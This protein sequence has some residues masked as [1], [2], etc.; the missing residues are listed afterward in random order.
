MLAL[1]T[2]LV[3]LAL[4]VVSSPALAANDWW[5]GESVGAVW[6]LEEG[7]ETRLASAGTVFPNAATLA[8][9]PTGRALLVHESESVFVGPSTVIAL[10]Q[11]GGRTRVIQIAGVA[12]FEVERR[13]VQHFTVETPFLAAVVKGTHFTVEVDDGGARVGVERGTVEVTGNESRQRTDL[14]AGMAAVVT[15]DNPAIGLLGGRPPVVQ[16]ASLGSHSSAQE[17]RAAG[18]TESDEPAAGADERAAGD[19]NNTGTG[20]GGTASA[21][22]EQD[23]G[24]EDDDNGHGNDDDHDDDDNPARGHRDD[25]SGPG[26]GGED[27]SGPGGGDDS[28]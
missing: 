5:I 8:T 19:A 13:N 9:S 20:V 25:H 27:N 3:L 28:D 10:L 17:S 23:G 14:T 11:R 7:K 22:G 21:V 2:R 12:E 15:A 26:G 18:S 24:D 6:I 16:V 1:W 4:F